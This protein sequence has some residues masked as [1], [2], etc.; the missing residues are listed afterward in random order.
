MIKTNVWYTGK[1]NYQ[2]NTHI[3][4]YEDKLHQYE[5]E[6]LEDV[7]IEEDRDIY[8]IYGDFL[9][10]RQ[11][12]TVQ[13]LFSG[14][15]DSELVLHVCL[16]NKIPVEAV[17]MR[18]IAYGITLNTHDLYH[19]KE[20]CRNNNIKHIVI[21]LDVIKF[22]ETGKHFEYLDEYLIYGPHVSTHFW[23]FEQCTGFPVLGGEY[24][25]PWA[26]KGDVAIVSP[27]R[28]QFMQ[29]DR[30]LK[31][32]NIHGIGNMQGY[33]FE[34][35]ALLTSTHINYLKQHPENKLDELGIIRLKQ[36]IHQS[37]G[38]I[39]A[40]P[41]PRSFGWEHVNPTVFDI[42]GQ[43][44]ILKERYCDT[45][46]LIKWGPRFAKILGSELRSNSRFN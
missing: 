18:L 10:Q 34:S 39:K 29:Y 12:K 20:Y 22:F 8:S 3:I 6:L 46:N 15:L 31:D 14:G 43:L 42:K 1:D 35:N 37:L 30:F 4:N 9:T 41:R 40:E 13:V 26:G 28:Y 21:D 19:S 16:K 2:K 45:T 32:R 24:T 25:W 44:A 17:T 33:S 27:I 23:L 7:P 36:G 11:T 5:L 38:N